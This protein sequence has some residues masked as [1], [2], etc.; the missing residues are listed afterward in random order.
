MGTR[1]GNEI[2][3]T[4]KPEGLLGEMNN[5]RRETGDGGEWVGRGRAKYRDKYA[6]NITVKT[7]NVYYN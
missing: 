7:T 6:W 3:A 4:W 2:Y 1:K 5:S